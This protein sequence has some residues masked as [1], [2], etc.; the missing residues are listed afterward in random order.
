VLVQDAEVVVVGQI[1]LVGQ[2]L[3]FVAA[4]PPGG[5]DELELPQGVVVA[6]HADHLVVEPVDH[7][8]VGGDGQ[9]GVEGPQRS[10]R[11]LAAQQARSVQNRLE[12]FVAPVAGLVYVS[13][14]AAKLIADRH[15]RDHRPGH[16]QQGLARQLRLPLLQQHL[17][18][19]FG[20]VQL[21][22][23]D[24]GR[25]HLGHLLQR[26]VGLDGP[27]PLGLHGVEVPRFDQLDHLLRVHRHLTHSRK[28]V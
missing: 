25:E 14:L 4:G 11:G 5:V 15:A 13:R 17:G 18:A 9:A 3:G 23:V 28:H 7:V 10:P 21:L 6:G 27:Q 19:R 1:E 20:C 26:Q 22:R 8:P 16:R 12:V 2:L 24:Q